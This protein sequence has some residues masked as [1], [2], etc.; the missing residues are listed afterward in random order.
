MKD[1]YEFGSMSSRPNP[2]INE[3]KYSKQ[4][5]TI[6]LSIEVI[7]YFKDMAKQNNIPYQNLID[8]YLKDCVKQHKQLTWV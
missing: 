3:L 4:D 1:E 8:M 5:I 7:E 2:Y 6:P